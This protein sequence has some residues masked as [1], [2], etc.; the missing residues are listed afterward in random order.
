MSRREKKGLLLNYLPTPV[1]LYGLLPGEAFTMDGIPTELMK[2]A[3]MGGSTGGS[4]TVTL[5]RVGPLRN[6]NM[7]SVLFSVNGKDQQFEVKDS[8]GK[9][10]F[11][12]PMADSKK[13]GQMGSPMPGAV[14]K[15]L[16]SEGQMV[17]Q[18]DTLCTISAMK[19]EVK[20]TAPFDG[21][22]V[23]LSVAATTRV[24]EGALLL[25]LAP[26]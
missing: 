22:V 25:T 6:G 19:M 14:E 5:K 12:G 10:E 17:S 21:K 3:V 9:F 24:V 23:S 15:L 1:Y 8:S 26:L 11:E 16:V 13:A 4:I 2:D 18:G 20:V 7:R